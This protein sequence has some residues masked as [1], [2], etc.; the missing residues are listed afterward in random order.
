M[1]TDVIRYRPEYVAIKLSV[2][3]SEICILRENRQIK[4]H[5]YASLERERRNVI[6]VLVVNISN[7]S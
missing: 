7:A 5:K 2:C 4:T 3:H 1:S 6:T